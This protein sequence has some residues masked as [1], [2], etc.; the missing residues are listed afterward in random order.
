[1]AS[2]CTGRGTPTAFYLAP[3]GDAAAALVAQPAE[4][5]A[6]MTP[7]RDAQAE[8]ARPTPTPPCTPGLLYLEDLS[9]PDGTLVVPGE[10]LDKRWLVENNGSCNWDREYSLQLIAGPNLGAPDEQALFPARSGARATVRILFTAPQE[11]GVYRSAWQ[12]ADKDGVLFGD[13]IYIEIVVETP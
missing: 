1:M 8:P 3:A 11:P 5:T 10:A 13:P 12:A 6:A 9:I 7:T 4:P 2:A